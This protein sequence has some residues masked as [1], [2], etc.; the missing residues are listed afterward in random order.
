M[1]GIQLQF[2]SSHNGN[3]FGEIT[4]DHIRSI[5]ERA[6]ALGLLSL[7]VKESLTVQPA[8]PDDAKPCPICSMPMDDTDGGCVRH[9]PEEIAAWVKPAAPTDDEATIRALDNAYREFNIVDFAVVR[10][11]SHLKAIES[12]VSKIRRGE[13]PG[14]TTTDLRDKI[15]CKAANDRDAAL[16]GMVKAEAEVERLR[17]ELQIMAEWRDL[18]KKECDAAVARA[19]GSVN[20]ETHEYAV[21]M[22]ETA[23][24]AHAEVLELLR[25]AEDIEGTARECREW[26]DA[27]DAHFAKYGKDASK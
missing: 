22:A 3:M 7:V 17:A 1:T 19:E 20:K 21:R 12:Q 5:V 14:L 10:Q 11:R 27:R 24:A 9:D 6:N 23:R 2:Y 8:A 15:V 26:F 16:A 25:N 13:V 4:D 18:E